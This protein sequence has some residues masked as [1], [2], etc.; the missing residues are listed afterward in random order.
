MLQ[1]I[2]SALPS[3]PAGSALADVRLEA[4]ITRCTK[5]HGHWHELS[6]SCDEAAKAGIT[7]P[8]NQLWFTSKSVCITGPFQWFCLQARVSDKMDYEAE[9]GVVIGQRAWR[10]SRGDARRGSQLLCR[11]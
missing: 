5:I 2:R 11:Q 9:L 4:P 6:G 7:I 3:A 1:Q 8:K 10:M